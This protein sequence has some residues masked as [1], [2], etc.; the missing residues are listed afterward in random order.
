MTRTVTI[1]CDRCGRTHDA[2][3]A[4]DS[5]EWVVMMEERVTRGKSWDL[6]GACRTRFKKDFMATAP[7]RD[8]ITGTI[9]FPLYDPEDEPE[10][11][12]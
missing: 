6:C 2:E 9:R 8:R 10:D 11:D 7:E 4:D 1:E 12:R 3:D 5:E